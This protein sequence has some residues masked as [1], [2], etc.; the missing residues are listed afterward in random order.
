MIELANQYTELSDTKFIL[1]DTPMKLNYKG[2]LI[3]PDTL[4]L[5]MER[6]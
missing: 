5:V 6:S 3:R 2:K 1:V 4:C